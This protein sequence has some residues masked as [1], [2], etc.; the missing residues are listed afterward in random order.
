MISFGAVLAVCEATEPPCGG[1]IGAELV[2]AAEAAGVDAVWV[3]AAAFGASLA[4]V[5]AFNQDK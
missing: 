4:G 1:L 3:G 2:G 5:G